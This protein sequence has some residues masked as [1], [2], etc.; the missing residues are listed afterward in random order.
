MRNFIGLA[1]LSAAAVMAAPAQAA[2]IVYNSTP[3]VGWHFGNGND[4]T[5]NAAVLTN[6]SGYQIYL[7][8]HERL[9][10]PP[11]S[12]DSGVYSFAL[13]TSPL[14]FDWGVSANFTATGFG[15][16]NFF[17]YKG[18]SAL[19]TVTNL[20]TSVVRTVNPFVFL[21]NDY[22]SG[23]A[24]N[25]IQLNWAD[26]FD[27]NENGLYE[28]NLSVS[29]GVF[30]NGESLSI[31]AKLGDGLNPGGTGAVPEPASWAMLIAGFALVGASMRRRRTAISF[32]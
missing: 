23:S 1:A 15:D 28:I 25:S 8:A 30:G 22:K 13:G 7:R 5:N 3:T 21:D 24:Q 10:T 11:A 29:G 26:L 9:V 19:V 14:N 6:D 2:V 32:A 27:P 20:D 18:V 12:D 4:S 17:N 16:L 31:F